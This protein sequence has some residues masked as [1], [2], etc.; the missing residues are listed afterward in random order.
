[1]L[2]EISFH[3]Q[4]GVPGLTRYSSLGEDSSDNEVRQK[5]KE[6][7]DSE[8]DYENDSTKSFADEISDED[9]IPARLL[10]KLQASKDSESDGDSESTYESDSESEN[11]DVPLNETNDS[12][13]EE[14]EGPETET[15]VDSESAEDV[16]GTDGD[17][18]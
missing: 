10:E 7:V 16:S 3:K 14:E 1:M 13:S 5:L 9:I 4:E 18:D 15:V 12:K 2:S 17:S 6:N 11:S 8:S